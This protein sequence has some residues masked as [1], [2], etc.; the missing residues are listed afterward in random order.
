[1]LINDS[2]DFWYYDDS[3]TD[4]MVSELL[5]ESAAQDSFF[6]VD[7]NFAIHQVLT[8]KKPLEVHAF[9]FAGDPRPW[10]IRIYTKERGAYSSGW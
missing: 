7:P 5:A 4:V 8:T 3:L 1:M 2:F 10:I 9:D 6:E